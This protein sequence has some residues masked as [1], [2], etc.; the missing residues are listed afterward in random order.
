MDNESTYDILQELF[1]DNFSD[2]SVRLS[3]ELLGEI[4]KATSVK[5]AKI[6]E[7]IK[8]SKN[9]LSDFR[10]ECIEII[11]EM[12]YRDGLNDEFTSLLLK[13]ESIEFK[14]HLAF[15]REME[16]GIHHIE[17]AQKLE[18]FKE[19]ESSIEDR[20][21]EAAITLQERKKLLDQ[22]KELDAKKSQ[23]TSEVSA[24]ESIMYSDSMMHDEIPAAA[25]R[26]A[27][28]RSMFIRIAA[29]L[30]LVLIPTS[31]II[32]LIPN[33]STPTNEKSVQTAQKEEPNTDSDGEEDLLMG[34]SPDFSMNIKV[35]DIRTER[36]VLPIINE[37]SFGFAKE[38]DSIEIVYQYYGA[39]NKYLENILDTIN[40][41]LLVLDTMF[42]GDNTQG[43]PGTEPN[44]KTRKDQKKRLEAELATVDSLYV[45]NMM[46]SNTYEYKKNK[47]TIHFHGVKSGMSY[48]ESHCR[49]VES[50]ILHQGAHSHSVKSVIP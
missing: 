21:I 41:K 46:N 16:A 2:T 23:G 30:V 27:S 32:F 33:S 48:Q 25:S 4:L 24:S 39:Q 43:V 35:P 29:I 50:G 15:L 40:Q 22:F 34:S 17:R 38:I 6:A 44:F 5:L 12:H 28:N 3:S 19:L 31:I 8:L 14:E 42:I 49:D 18:E 45:Q 1:E 37:E 11:T 20:E 36:M 7:E 26:I 47:I 13:N 10:L 9:E